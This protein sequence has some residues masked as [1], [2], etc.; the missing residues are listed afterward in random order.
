[1]RY[2]RT[3]LAG[4]IA[5]AVLSVQAHAQQSEPEQCVDLG[6]ETPPGLYVTVDQSQ[7]YLTKDGKIVELNPGEAA[8]ANETQLTC[9]NITPSV[10]DWP[11]G[12][13]ED[14]ARAKAEEYTLD[15]LPAIGGIQEIKRRYF[16][17]KK[18]LGPTIEWLNGDIHG[19]FPLSE[20]EGVDTTKS[21][22][23][24]TTDDPFASPKRPRAQVIGLFWATKQMIVDGNTF[25]AIQQ[26]FPDGEIPVVFMFFEQQQVPISFF[27]PNP[28]LK[29][30]LDAYFER[31]IEVAPPPV[32]YA[33]E[34]TLQVDLQE[35]QTMFDLPPVDSLDPAQVASMKADIER[36]GFKTKPFTVSAMGESGSIF[37]DQPAKLS[38]AASMG[39]TSF[40]VVLQH[41]GPTSHLA[42]C[43][44][45]RPAIS[46]VGDAQSVDELPDDVDEVPE[47]PPPVI[48]PPPEDDRSDG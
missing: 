45:P 33:G 5:L 7:V 29:T 12:T 8:Y 17:D 27:G 10:L 48:L 41:F 22:Y 14:R 44:I 34:F 6:Q 16:E 26:E 32:W 13:A 30:V 39:M 38:V 2:R 15:E 24:R 28:S 23:Q 36:D 9:L 18:V 1:M 3:P 47:P 37:L 40:P 31:G 43:D 21:W 11:C 20:F 42:D 35:V 25:E 46:V 19:T 4:C